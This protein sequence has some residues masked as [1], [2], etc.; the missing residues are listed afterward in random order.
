VVWENSGLCVR[1]GLA[2]IPCAEHY[3]ITQKY[4]TFTLT[5]PSWVKDAHVSF[6]QA[7]KNV[8]VIGA[9]HVDDP[10]GGGGSHYIVNFPGKRPWPLDKN[11]DPVV[12]G[13]LDQLTT[14]TGYPLLVVK[15]ALIEGA[16][17]EK[18]CRLN[19]GGRLIRDS[20]QSAPKALNDFAH[21]Q[22]SRVVGIFWFRSNKRRGDVVL[23]NRFGKC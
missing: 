16:L 14:I 1:I 19:W 21:G 3:S 22:F 9:S 11:H 12:P 10:R 20:F 15:Y 17:P 13:Y 6:V 23:S 8:T 2:S 7:K 5:R 18:R 4:Q